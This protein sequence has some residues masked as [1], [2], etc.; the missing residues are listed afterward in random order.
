MRSSFFAA[1]LSLSSIPFWAYAQNAPIVLD[2]DEVKSISV[3]GLEEL[4][5]VDGDEVDTSSNGTGLVPEMTNSIAGPS[6]E[7]SSADDEAFFDANNMVP[8]GEMAQDG[9]VNVNPIYQPASK[10]VLVR[11]TVAADERSAALV[12][13]E[14][15]MKLGIYDSA[16]QL[17]DDLYLE[18]KKD[19]RVLMGRAVS[20]QKL[21]RFDE[22]M[23]VYEELESVAPDDIVAKVNMLGLLG[24]RYPSIAL[25]RLLELHS[26]NKDNVLLTGQ[27]AVAYAKSGD[28]RSALK[29]LGIAASMEPR[30]A[31]HVFNM[32]VLS[33]RAGESAKAVSFYERALEIDTI[34]G[35][36]RSIPRDS[37]YERLAQIR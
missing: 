32:A 6:A 28:L 23:Q 1:V 4:N 2:T 13:A 31:S 24:T 18:N 36:G 25:R 12:A 10:L 11:K 5:T 7:K 8:Q 26:E 30:N 16:L 17:F 22:A 15:A 34:H 37:V 20:L 27:L 21:G 35:G 3:P 9:P 29:Y 33:D 14:R 19:A